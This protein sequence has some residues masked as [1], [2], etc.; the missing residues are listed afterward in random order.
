MWPCLL[1]LGMRLIS[2]WY[3]QHKPLQSSNIS[4]HFNM[5]SFPTEGLHCP[6]V[7][8]GIA[9]WGPAPAGKTATQPC[10]TYF[11]GFYEHVSISNMLELLAECSGLI[12]ISDLLW[13]MKIDGCRLWLKSTGVL[14]L[15]YFAAEGSL[16]LYSSVKQAFFFWRNWRQCHIWKVRLIIEVIWSWSKRGLLVPI[17]MHLHF[18]ENGHHIGNNPCL[19]TEEPMVPMNIRPM[20]TTRVGQNKK[21]GLNYVD[22]RNLPQNNGGLQSA[23]VSTLP[24][25]NHWRQESNLIIAWYSVL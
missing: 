19:S 23:V 1:L 10:P 17:S 7:F 16:H 9:C 21:K 12:Y 14:C 11:N 2:Y 8:D 13:V 25:K 24:P 5:M 15:P 18:V 22:G 20:H 6:R 3:V 4:L